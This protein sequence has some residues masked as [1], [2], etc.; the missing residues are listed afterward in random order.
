M[1]CSVNDEYKMVAF[2]IHVDTNV[3]TL[4]TIGV[5]YCSLQTPEKII[6]TDFFGWSCKMF[7]ESVVTEFCSSVHSNNTQLEQEVCVHY[8]ITFNVTSLH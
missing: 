8:Q 3:M 7:E 2:R 5:V 4:V 6:E 1:C